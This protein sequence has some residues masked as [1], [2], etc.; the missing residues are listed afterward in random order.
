MPKA[1]FFVSIFAFGATALLWLAAKPSAYSRTYAPPARN[2]DQS[3]ILPLDG[4]RIFGTIVAPA[5]A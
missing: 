2:Q 5:M 1:R 4:A 3:T